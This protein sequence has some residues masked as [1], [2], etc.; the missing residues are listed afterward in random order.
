MN[1]D[2]GNYFNN[3]K[4]PQKEVALALRKIIKK[5][6]PKIKEEMKYGVPY[7]EDKFYIVALKDHVNLGFSIIGLSK[8]E[9]VLFDGGGK[10]TKYIAV[11]SPKKIDEKKIVKLLK[12]VWNK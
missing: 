3:Q 10:T 9:I 4:S 11:D 5:T 7:Y 1:T 6:F 8:D 2:V 12:L